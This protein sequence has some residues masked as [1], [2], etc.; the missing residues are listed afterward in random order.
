[1]NVYW[2]TLGF[3]VGIDLG[4]LDGYFD[5]SNDNKLGRIL[6]EGS[7]GSTDGI[8]LGSDEGTNLGL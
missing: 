5:G 8:V 6:I 2:I 7:L 3:D 4:S 1:M